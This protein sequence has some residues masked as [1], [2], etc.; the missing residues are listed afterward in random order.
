MNEAIGAAV[1]VWETEYDSVKEREDV[2]NLIV[3]YHA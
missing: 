1:F 3:A 2:V